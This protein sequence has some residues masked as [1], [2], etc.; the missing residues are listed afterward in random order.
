MPTNDPASLPR[1]PRPST[2]RAA[3]LP[4]L[5]LLLAALGCGDAA[6]PPLTVVELGERLFHD[7]RLSLNENQSCATCHDPERAFV[8]ARL[9][10]AG[11]VRAVSLGDD[12]VSL[13]DR[14]APTAAY[15]AFAPAFTV[16][17]RQRFNKQGDH[18]LYEGPLG[19]V[20]WDGRAGG[21]AAQAGG[22]PLNPIEMGM[23]DE[24][25][26]AL[27]LEADPVYEAS[28]RAAFGDD[29]F[30]DPAAAYAAM[31][32]AIAAYERTEAFAPF[33]SKYDRSLR[34]EAQL[35]FKE[36]T[37]KSLF[38]SEF[39]NCAICHQLHGNGDP[40][41]KFEETFTG[42]EFHN[43]GVPVNRAAREDNGVTEPD[44]GLA[45]NPAADPV[46][47]RGKFRT[48]TLRNV[49]VT[50]PYMH[51]GVF[52]QLRTAVELYAHHLD[53]EGRPNNPETGAPWGD[54]EIPETVATELLEVGDPLSDDD[55]E[56]LVCFLRTLTDQRYEPLI[57]DEGISCAD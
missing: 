46:E 8:D 11:E 6:P 39:A 12:G 43:I 54:P 41:K 13:G 29:V 22:P 55:I 32:E 42:Y 21:L 19:G 47:D 9:D 20:F 24:A 56:A 4:A 23:P 15:A 14:N 34:G 51:N 38:F 26:V 48:P 2:A 31:T 30:E 57:E 33:D 16:G 17:T 25:S 35:S 18:R 40:V 50:G 37:G 7:V 1:R 3:G 10:G 44:L 28:L 27:R 52:R 49:A 45:L 36:L 5:S 53:P